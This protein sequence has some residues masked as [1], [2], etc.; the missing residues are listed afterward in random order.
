MMGMFGGGGQPEPKGDISQLWK[1]LG[2][3]M[4]GDEVVWQ[5]FDPE[6]K[7]GDIYKEWI[8]VDEAPPPT[9]TANPFDPDDAIS[10]GMRQVCCLHGSFRPADRSKLGFQ[11]LAVTGQNSGTISYPDVDMSLRSGNSI[12]VHRVTTH[13]PYII[14]THVTGDFTPDAG[15]YLKDT[16]RTTPRATTRRK[17]PKPTPASPLQR[18]AMPRRQKATRRSSGRCAGR[19]GARKDEDR[20]RAGGRYR[21]DRADHFAAAQIGQDYG[22]GR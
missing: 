9:G 18:T 3:E 14:A 1:L 6:P 10:A 2:V 7:L 21:L 8:F 22:F 12:G 16:T 15:L 5:D 19:E 17:T 13:E 11:K 4:Y 20:C